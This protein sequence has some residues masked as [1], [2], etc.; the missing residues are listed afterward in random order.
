M[1]SFLAEKR[2]AC[3]MFKS[4]S[5]PILAGAGALLAAGFLTAAPAQALQFTFTS[6]HVDP[7]CGTATS[8]GT[9]TVLQSGTSVTFDVVLSDANRFVE[10]GS[11]D[12]QLF[13]FNDSSSTA[14]ITNP[15]TGMPA[16]AVTGGLIGD[17]GPFNGDGT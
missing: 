15:L 13:K 12:Q 2:G 3:R 7:D 11:A 14:V 4:K 16:N 8:F 6:C 9:V 10:T 1:C 5:L 17:T